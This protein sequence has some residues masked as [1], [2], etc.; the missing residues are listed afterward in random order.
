M[1]GDCQSFYE[2]GR[3]MCTQQGWYE[4]SLSTKMLLRSLELKQAVS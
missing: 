3:D 2:V 4:D 1:K